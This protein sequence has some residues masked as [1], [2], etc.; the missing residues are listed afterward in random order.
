[1]DM[2]KVLGQKRRKKAAPSRHFFELRKKF[3]PF[4]HFLLEVLV[5][6]LTLCYTPFLS[7]KSAFAKP[8]RTDLTTKYSAE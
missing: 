8:Q 2:E 5:L 3:P 6:L 4:Y 7:A 1:M